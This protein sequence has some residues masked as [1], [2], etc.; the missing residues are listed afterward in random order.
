MINSELKFTLKEVLPKFPKDFQQKILHSVELLRKAEKL[1]LAYDK[2][3]GFYLSTSMG[4]DSQCLYH[5]T[6]L[7]GVKFKAHMALTSVDPPEVIKFGREQYPDVD[8]IKP[9]ISI[10]NQARKEGILPTRLMRWCCRIYK[11]G[12]G[13]G[14]V[15]L[16]GIRH[17]E[18]RQ[19]SNRKEV[20]IS[21]HKYSG[22]L[23]GLDEFREKRNSQKRGRPTH[24]G[25]HEINITNATDEHTI[26]CIR[27]HESLIISPIIEW[28]DDEVWM[29]LKTLGIKYCKLY[30]EGYHRI[31][32][33]C[34]P[35]HGYRQKLADCKRYPHIYKSWLKVIDDIHNGG[36]L[37][38][39]GLTN[40]DYFDWWIS[41]VGIEAWRNRRKQQTLNFKD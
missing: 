31:G 33:L 22:T 2:E 7:A 12:I 32:C 34:C 11:E 38:T 29:F 17:T 20:E 19:R 30:D 41:G 14:K 37:D 28:T 4:K 9:S 10:Y 21:N 26:G 6:K 35:M 15:T 3:N 1:A 40:E 8:F 39:F 18:S 23:D 24:G 25:V 5:I 13:A 27:G 16:I 36:K